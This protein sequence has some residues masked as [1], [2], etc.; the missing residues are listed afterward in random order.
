MATPGQPK[1]PESKTAVA[2]FIVLAV[3]VIAVLL[4]FTVLPWVSG[5][6]TS[7][8]F[9]DI[10]S[11]NSVSGTGGLG[12]AYFK[13]LGWVVLVVA[14]GFA[15]AANRPARSQNAWRSL[16]VVLSVVGIAVTYGAINDLD[17][18]LGNA[19]AA[20]WVAVIGFVLIGAAA[21]VPSRPIV[22]YLPSYGMPTDQQKFAQPHQPTPGSMPGGPLGSTPP[23]QYTYSQPASAPSPAPAPATMVAAGWM[24]DPARRYELRYWDGTRWT[25]NVSTGGNQFVDPI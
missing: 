10:R 18:R 4:A 24:T 3:G 14:A 19:S 8:N 25:E 6:G 1:P 11:S 17:I 9:G 22:H 21:L 2:G 20:F 15:V 23:P 13:W 16:G 7:V 5:E 12:G